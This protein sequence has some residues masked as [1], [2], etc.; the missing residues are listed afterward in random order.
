MKYVPEGAIC[1][2]FYFIVKGGIR[3]YFLTQHGHDK[4]RHIALE[5]TI[6]T[7]LSSFIS[8]KPSVEIIDALEDTELYSINRTNFFHFVQSYRCWELFYQ[9][10][11]ETAYMTQTQRIETRVTLSAKQRYDLLCK[12]NPE[13]I[14]RVSNRILA[15]YLDITQETLS[16]LKSH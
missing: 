8:C 10:I 12:N 14:Q 15:S 4:T 1:N 5:N 9:L 16:R 6:I 3:V 13:Y 7:A 2:D 11:L